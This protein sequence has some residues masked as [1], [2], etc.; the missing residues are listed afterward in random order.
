[1]K[2]LNKMILQMQCDN[3]VHF[4]SIYRKHEY[5]VQGL[6]MKPTTGVFFLLGN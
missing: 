4:K 1:M 3:W 6:T 5:Y 2:N